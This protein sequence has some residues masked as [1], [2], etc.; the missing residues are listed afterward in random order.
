M[1]FWQ[2]FRYVFKHPDTILPGWQQSKRLFHN[3]LT[4]S[5]QNVRPI[6]HRSLQSRKP[7]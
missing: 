5:T 6:Y 7:K 4:G 3:Q 1:T 2:L